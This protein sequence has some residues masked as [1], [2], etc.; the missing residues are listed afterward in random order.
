MVAKVY[1]NNEAKIP[2]SV[3][4]NVGLPQR[5][6]SWTVPVYVLKKKAVSEPP[7]EEV[8]V[9]EGPLHPLPFQPPC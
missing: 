1:L 3:K 4:V 5:G 8:Y 2:D 9:T 7:E 6:H